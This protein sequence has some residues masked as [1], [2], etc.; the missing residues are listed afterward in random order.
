[1]ARTNIPIQ[2]I[3]PGRAIPTVSWTPADAAND[4]QFVSQ[5][6]EILLTRYLDAGS[7]TIVVKSVADQLHG[8]TGDVTISVTNGATTTKYGA[9][10]PFQGEGFLQAGSVIHIDVTTGTNLHLAVVRPRPLED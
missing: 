9:A 5:G 2:T 1:M 4:H 6:D 3:Q 8:F 10:G 7:D